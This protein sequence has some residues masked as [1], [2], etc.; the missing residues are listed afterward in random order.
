M[1]LASSSL[2]EILSKSLENQNSAL[3]SST[4]HLYQNLIKPNKTKTLPA[5]ST[6]HLIDL[7]P[8]C[9]TCLISQVL[10][11]FLHV[12]MHSTVHILMFSHYTYD[13]WTLMSGIVKIMAVNIQAS[14]RPVTSLKKK[15]HDNYRNQNLYNLV[16][17]H[18]VCIQNDN[19]S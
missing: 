6:L 3:V 13:E 15:H 10:T 14:N 2:F 12:N 7:F 17:S 11:Y 1:S 16:L 8:R 18:A 4:K 5:F 19:S 9:S